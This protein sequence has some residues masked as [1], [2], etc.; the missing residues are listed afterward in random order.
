MNIRKFVTIKDEAP[1]LFFSILI[2]FSC[3]IALLI[4]P[5]DFQTGAKFYYLATY[6]SLLAF[7]LHFEY[8]IKDKRKLLLPAAMLLTGIVCIIWTAIYKQPDDYVVLYRQY[9]STG[10]LQIA[11]AFLLAF[12]LNDPRS[13]QKQTTVLAIVA[14]IAV[15]AYALYQ[16]IVMHIA[17]VELNYD[18]ATIAAYIITVVNL[19]FLNAVL[20][21]KKR[22][23]IPLFL[24]IFFITFTTLVLT[25]TRAAMLTF[26]VLAFVT[27]LAS[28]HMLSNKHKVITLILIP[29]LIGSCGVIF[30]TRVEDRVKDFQENIA[31]RHEKTGDNSIISRMSMQYAAL[32]TG[33]EALMGQSAEQRGESI[34]QMVKKHPELY[35]VLPYLTVHMHNE[36]LEAFSL[37][38]IPG[39][40]VLLALYLCLI[41]H[42]FWPQRNP[43]LLVISL[44]L[45]VYGLSDVI[46]FSAQGT[47]MYCLGIVLSILMIQDPRVSRK[48]S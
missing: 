25:G 34:K 22:L 36:V 15:N 18:R 8:Y 31:M 6:I 39:V 37:K 1:H 21:L 17:R 13:W 23:R 9:Q 19:L 46:F 26:P 10:R 38:G 32:H 40:L 2:Y 14:G 28:K 43:V 5:F 29:L 41:T 33:L 7:I 20:L 45:I 4:V 35:G 3:A 48:S 24:I 12:S 44:S 11:T 30:K 16:G 42:S 47:L 27:I